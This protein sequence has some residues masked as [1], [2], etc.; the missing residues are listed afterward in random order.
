MKL[1]YRYK[2]IKFQNIMSVWNVNS[3]ESPYGTFSQ[4]ATLNPY[5]SPYDSEGRLVQVLSETNSLNGLVGNPLYDATLSTRLHTNN[6]NYSNNFYV[7]VLPIDGC[8]PSHE[9]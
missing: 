4:Y 1:E 3:K 2:K 6:L 8:G 7:E 5:W 9:S